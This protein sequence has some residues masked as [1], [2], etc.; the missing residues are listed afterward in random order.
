MQTGQADRAYIVYIYL[1]KYIET[2]YAWFSA[3]MYKGEK[4]DAYSPV[5]LYLNVY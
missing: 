5:T 4:H 3:Y 1:Y 2:M